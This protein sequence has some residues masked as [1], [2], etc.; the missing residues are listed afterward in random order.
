MN[1]SRITPVVNRRMNNQ[2][3]KLC[4]IGRINK[5]EALKGQDKMPFLIKEDKILMNGHKAE[6]DSVNIL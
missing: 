6:A 4:R 1:F 5:E 3:T 2:C